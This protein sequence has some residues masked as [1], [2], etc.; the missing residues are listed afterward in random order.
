[1]PKQAF[2]LVK[3]APGFEPATDKVIPVGPWYGGLDMRLPPEDV[4]AGSTP[5]MVDMEVASDGRLIVAPGVTTDEALTYTPIQVYLIQGNAFNTKMLLIAPPFLGVK[6]FGAT[7]WYNMGLTSHPYGIT[8]F[9]GVVL[10]SDG[11]K[12][13]FAIPP[14]G[15]QPSIATVPNAPAGLA[16]GVFAGRVLVGATIISGTFDYMGVNWS[17]ATLDYQGWSSLDGAGGQTLIGNRSAADRIQQFVSLGFSTLAVMNRRSIWL[18]TKTG[19]VFQPIDFNPQLEDIGATHAAAVVPSEYG[20]IFLSDS[21]VRIFDGNGTT[22]ISDQISSALIPVSD[23]DPW[24]MSLDPSRRRLYVCGPTSTYIYDLIRK[25]WFQWGNNFLASAFWPAQS[26]D[27]TTWANQIPGAWNAQTLAWWQLRPQESNGQMYFVRAANIGH[28][29][30]TSFAVFGNNLL[31]SW[32]DR[33]QVDA[34]TDNLYTTLG[35]YITYEGS[36]T[37]NLWLPDENGDPTLVQSGVSLPAATTAIPSNAMILESG[38]TRITESGSLRI[39][40]GSIPITQPSGT[41]RV[42]VPLVHSGRTVSLGIQVTAGSPR[43]RKASVRFQQTSTL[44]A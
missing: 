42:Y 10:L 28:E 2:Q 20:V 13:L 27:V 43:I 12:S 17:D 31:P 21:G 29:D 23:T 5:D 9:A 26:A 18:G 16:L 22:L 25:R 4:A 34:D 19:D 35:V 33:Q 8:N 39:T 44:N 36:G 11:I 3:P 30:P 41:N 1:M 40:E 7:Q 37:V 32:F 24:S 14:T 38:D 6:Q 15:G